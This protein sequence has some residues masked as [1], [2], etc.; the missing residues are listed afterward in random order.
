MPKLLINSEE[1]DGADDNRKMFEIFRDPKKLRFY[2][3][4]AHGTQLFDSVKEAVTEDIKEFIKC[5][6]P[7]PGIT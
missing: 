2:P 5:A 3:G 4:N 6:L 1:D 7:R